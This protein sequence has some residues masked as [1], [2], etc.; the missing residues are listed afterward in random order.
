MVLFIKRH[1]V[2]LVNAKLFNMRH[3][4]EHGL[5]RLFLEKIKRG[6]QQCHI[7]AK[8]ID[9]ESLDK[10]ALLLIEKFKCPYKGSK[11]T[12]AIDIGDEQDGCTQMFCD[13]HIH[14][15]VCLEIDLGGTARPLNHKQIVFRLETVKSFLD[16]PPRFE[17]IALVIFTRTH[18]ADRLAHDDNLRL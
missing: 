1:G 5:S 15:I 12:A 4:T 7:T 6:C 13:T 3:N 8:F 11:R 18:V 14:N 10:R 17:R 2:L 16:R 9:D